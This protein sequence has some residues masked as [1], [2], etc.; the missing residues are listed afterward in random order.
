ME[1]NKLMTDVRN[2]QSGTFKIVIGIVI[3]ILIL[4]SWRDIEGIRPDGIN[5]ILF[6]FRKGADAKKY[7]K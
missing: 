3:L 1:F 2:P 5:L 7:Q 4:S 6:F